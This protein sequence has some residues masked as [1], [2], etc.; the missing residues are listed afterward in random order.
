MAI[1]D[2][3]TFLIDRGGTLYKTLASDI[4]SYIESRI[5]TPGPWTPSNL[6]GTSEQGA[7]YEASDLTTLF[8]DNGGATPVAAAGQTVGLWLDKS[9]NDNHASQPSIVARPV[10]RTDAARLTIDRIDDQLVLTVP[11]GGFV[12]TMV[13]ATTE[14]TA[15]YG[16]NI[17]AGSYRL[18]GAFYPGS[19]IVGVIIRHGAMTQAQ[20]D[21]AIGYLRAN[22]GGL[23]YGS[24]TVFSNYW[25]NRTEITSFPLINT[26]SGTNFLAAWRDCSSLTSF[27][28]IDT[29]SGTIFQ[30]AW[31]GCSSL[32][33]F[34]LINTSSGTNL[35]N[36]WLGCS[37]LTSFPLIDTSV[38]INFTGT[39]S[40]C[41]SLTSFPLINTS[42]GTNFSGA[43]FG[44]SSLTSFPANFFDGCAATSFVNTFSNT[45]LSQASID[46]IL[47]SIESNGRS[48]GTFV[49]SGGSAPSATG[50]AAINAL[51]ARGWN[52]TVTGG[53]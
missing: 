4:L 39:W 37:S 7:W 33:S 40:G 27:P 49:Q 1:Q 3:D 42:S 22:G 47:V 17:P 34:P 26:S 11:A 20:I 50:Q 18:G 19:D 41:S 29:S 32:T 5:G 25:R 15:S 8:Q 30:A 36:A 48:N 2:S 14:G 31:A 52:V 6:F 35:A 9:G 23:D 24:T 46:G 51:R 53:Y 13:L 45:N 43:W 12:G 21:D 16:V 38:C 44:C 10:Y 28:L